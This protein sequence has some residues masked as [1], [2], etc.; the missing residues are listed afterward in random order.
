MKIK[1]A[2]KPVV[3]PPQV[4]TR[5]LKVFAAYSR[6]YVCR[7]FHAIGILKNG[8]P[9]SDVSGPMVIYLNHASWWDPLVC[10]HLARKFLAN[11]TSFAP[12]DAE[13][14][15][16]YGFFKHLGFYGI[17]RQSVR[18]AM[19]FLR[20]SCSLLGTARNAV[21][22]TPQGSFKDVR[23]RPVRLQHGI[24]LLATRMENVAFVPLAIEYVF[25]AEPRPEILLSFGQP[26]VPKDAPLRS[27]G[28]WT[29]FFGNALE[30]V[31]EELAVKSARRDP[32][33]WIVLEKG[34]SGI[35]AMYDTWRWLGSWIC[36]RQ[37]VRGH[38]AENSI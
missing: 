12:I 26:A 9:P 24:G 17:E 22:L 21:W 19:T 25:W 35:S 32:L 3:A 37:F 13:S 10:L 2:A 18:G 28:E 11:R 23:E 6:Q 20:I 27:S 14:L 8:L 31:Q 33:D 38:K 29:T 30:E 16:R 7:R 34:A 5:L 1:T 4:A 15:Q 36:G